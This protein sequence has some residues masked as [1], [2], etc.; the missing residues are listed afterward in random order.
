MKIST[1]VDPRGNHWPEKLKKYPCL[2]DK[3]QRT[4]KERD[5]SR[6]F[7]LSKTFALFSRF[8][9]FFRSFKNKN[10]IISNS[11]VSI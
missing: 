9:Y 4:Y 10:N 11:S 6:K 2:F 8:D 7:S 3:S 1:F 5:I